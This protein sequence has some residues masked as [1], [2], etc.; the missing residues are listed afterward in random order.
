MNLRVPRSLMQPIAVALQRRLH[1]AVQG[2]ELL[3]LSILLLGGKRLIPVPGRMHR[4]QLGQG[5]L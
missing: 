4:L 3:D 2:M 5:I 1:D